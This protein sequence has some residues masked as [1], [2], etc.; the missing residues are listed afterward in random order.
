MALSLHQR[1]HGDKRLNP[2]FAHSIMHC[3]LPFWKSLKKFSTHTSNP[4]P[5][6]NPNMSFVFNSAAE[7]GFAHRTFMVIL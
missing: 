5:L 6:Y 4:F 3:D 1:K 7:A 2:W